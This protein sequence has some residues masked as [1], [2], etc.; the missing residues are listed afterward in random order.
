MTNVLLPAFPNLK[1]PR[2]PAL[3]PFA[4]L[5]LVMLAAALWA[6][7]GVAVGMMDS[8]RLGADTLGFV[9]TLIGAAVLLAAAVATGGVPRGM[10]LP[11]LPLLVFGI[12]AAIF[13][14][15]LFRAF[16]E[17]GVTITVTVTVCLPPLILAVADAMFAR[18]L[19][20]A[21]VTTALVVAGAGVAAILLPGSEAHLLRPVNAGGWILLLTASFAFAG[22]AASARRLSGVVPP[23]FGTGLGLAIC[24]V[25]L[26]GHALIGG[27]LD[28]AQ[29]AT[30]ER[31]DLAILLY[32]GLFATGG[33]Y[34][35]FAVGIRLCRS[36]TSGLVASMIEPAIAA[37]LAAALLGEFLRPMELVGCA[38]VITAMVLIWRAE[39]RPAASAGQA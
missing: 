33:A 31:R 24:T 9:R 12:G 22:V 3:L 6:T 7:V 23:L 11:A 17:V 30:L 16:R 29:V 35:A 20:C 14:V 4:G 25:L 18:R 2:F 37:A 21:L 5:L 26:A 39:T 13:Q 34:L 8:H 28:M 19:P 1:G 27:S 15:C 10:R 32:L 36:S 38:G